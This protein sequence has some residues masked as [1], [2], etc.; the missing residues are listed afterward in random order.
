[1]NGYLYCTVGG[2]HETTGYLYNPFKTI[3]MHILTFINLY[4]S[5]T[6]EGFCRE[7]QR[8]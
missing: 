1:M 4:C 5:I 3:D 2:V 8:V 7:M 6:R